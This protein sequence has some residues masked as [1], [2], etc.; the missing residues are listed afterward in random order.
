MPDK[1]GPV[2]QRP[3]GPTGDAARPSP[4][5]RVDS[6]PSFQDVLKAQIDRVNQMQLDA[7]TAIEDLE[8]GRT[9]NVG[10]VFTAVQKADLA[11]KTLMQIRNKLLDAYNEIQRMRI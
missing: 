7:D 8:N 10:E 11:F 4:A 6:S 5:R 1:V 9:E 2:F 3:I